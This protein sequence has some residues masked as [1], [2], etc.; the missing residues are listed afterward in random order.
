MLDA[1]GRVPSSIFVPGGIGQGANSQF[2]PV[3]P[4]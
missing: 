3:R 2:G 1:S 4:T